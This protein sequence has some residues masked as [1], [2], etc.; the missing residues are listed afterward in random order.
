MKR[1][2]ILRNMRDSPG[3]LM[4]TRLSA[5]RAA[6]PVLGSSGGEETFWVGI[7]GGAAG[8]GL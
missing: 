7:Q 8:D 6:S 4:K 3:F 5:L 2:R 1:G